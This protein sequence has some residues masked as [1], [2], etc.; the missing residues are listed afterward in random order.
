MISCSAAGGCTTGTV[1]LRSSGGDQYAVRVGG[2]AGRTRIMRFDRGV[3]RWLA[4]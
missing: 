1:F 2:V 3:W 4:A